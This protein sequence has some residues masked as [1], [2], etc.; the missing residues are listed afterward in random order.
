MF[1]DKPIMPSEVKN[2]SAQTIWFRISIC[3]F[4]SVY[5]QISVFQLKEV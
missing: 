1:I 3:S 4:F 2:S 5:I